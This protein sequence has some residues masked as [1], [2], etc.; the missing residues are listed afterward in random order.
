MLLIVACVAASCQGPDH[1]YLQNG[2]G[3]QLA[4]PDMTNSTHMLKSYFGHLCDQS[5]LGSCPSS[6]GAD[7]RVW[8]LV[9]RQG[10][11]DIDRRCDAYLQWLDD[12][13]RTRGPLLNQ[14]K[15]IQSTTAALIGVFDPSNAVALQV[16]AQAFNLITRSIDNYH[17]RL[18]LE[19]ESSTVNTIVLRARHDMRQKIVRDSIT[20]RPDAEYALRTYLRVCLP[21]AIETNINDYGTLGARGIAVDEDTSINQAPVIRRAVDPLPPARDPTPPAP[22]TVLNSYEVNFGRDL[23]VQ[24]QAALCVKIDG[25]WGAETRAAIVEFYNGTGKPRPEIA[26]RGVRPDDMVTL[27]TAM[28][29]HPKCNATDAHKSAFE[30]GQ[31]AS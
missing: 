22:G 7:N 12:K 23:I 10:L 4:A 25:G 29:E 16:V 27:R 1:G 9:V 6:D 20:S 5:G 30:L 17:S 11:N 19:I 26:T 14:V 2:I 13:K 31:L 24:V 15:D 8:N 21:F 18:L 3:A 28:R